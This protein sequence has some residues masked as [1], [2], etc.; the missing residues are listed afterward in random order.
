[1]Q[2]SRSFCSRYGQSFGL[3]KVSDEELIEVIAK[4]EVQWQLAFAN[5]IGRYRGWIYRRCVMRL[6]SPYDAEDVTQDV[7][8]RLYH[9]LGG[10]E[11]RG[12]FLG[13]LYK[14]VDN[15][16]NT[17]AMRQAKYQST[18]RLDQLIEHF[19]I[20]HPQDT[21]HLDRASL[22]RR[23]LAILPAQARDIL[24][25][26]FFSDY[27]LELISRMQGVSLSATKMRLYRALDQ[28]KRLY[29]GIDDTRS[30]PRLR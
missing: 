20:T 26:R 17:F 25:L 30:M 24:Q 18:D 9:G 16:C 11:G 15:Q 28:F 12:S 2:T 4:K 21:D 1:M 10:F 3:P 5:L 14:V 7:V 8:L 19:Q 27:S 22:V 13:W 29:V 6:G 23:T